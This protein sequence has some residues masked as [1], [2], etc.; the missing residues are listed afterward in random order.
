MQYPRSLHLPAR[1]P[2]PAGR[3][4]SPGT[5]VDSRA[6]SGH[7]QA[8]PGVDHIDQF[9][10]SGIE[11]PVAGL[12]L[13][14][15]NPRRS[16]PAVPQPPCRVFGFQ[17]PRVAFA[18]VPGSARPA[19]SARPSCRSAA[20][21]RASPARRLPGNSVRRSEIRPAASTAPRRR[22]P[23][24]RA[25]KIPGAGRP[26]HALISCRAPPGP[27]PRS[28]GTRPAPGSAPARPA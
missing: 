17:R 28:A 21:P 27:G 16:W 25:A 4:L 12:R 23:P 20:S 13:R 19:G 18:V 26:D 24:V 9:P 15:D 5:A 7:R 3:S 8:A 10:R 22:P 1:R 6:L 11:I 2:S 14:P